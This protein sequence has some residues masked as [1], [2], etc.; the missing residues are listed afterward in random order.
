M[1][2]AGKINISSA[3]PMTSTVMVG[4]ADINIR[5]VE[6]GMAWHYKQYARERPTAESKSYAA[7]EDL[8]KTAKLGLWADPHVIPPCDWRK[9][10][11]QARAADKES[12]VQCDCATSD[13]C[14]GKRGGS[15]CLTSVGTK[16]FCP[17]ATR[18]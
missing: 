15:Y 2:N 18:R 17:L 10:R 9:G 8:A 4:Q 7:A 14:I 3:P 13:T 12:S 11:Q 16:R 5:Q 1:C 6:L